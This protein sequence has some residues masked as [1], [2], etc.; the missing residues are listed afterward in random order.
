MR[1]ARGGDGPFDGESMFSQDVLAKDET[2]QKGDPEKMDVPGTPDASLFEV[3]QELLGGS[4][5]AMEADPLLRHIRTRVTDEGLIIEVF[6][7]EGSPLFDGPTAEPEPIFEDLVQM[8]GRVLS[9]TVNPVA[10]T[11]HLATGDTGRGEAD[12]WRLSADR[13][14][15]TRGLPG[16][17][18]RGGRARLAGDRQ[19][20]PQPGGG[21]P[22]RPAQPPGGD[23][24]AAA[25][26][27]VRGV[28]R[29]CTASSPARAVS[30]SRPRRVVTNSRDRPGREECARLAVDPSRTKD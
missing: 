29:P 7:I 21:R 5:D 4:G 19:V 18:G 23:H 10:V 24:A 25:V 27:A 17:G 15:L 9:R 11:G 16:G 28:A 20:R 2:G 3:E 8:I 13:A 14:Q 1:A 12:P 6:D 26:R 30:R 22:A